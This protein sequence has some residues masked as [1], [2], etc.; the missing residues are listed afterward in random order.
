MI[1][2]L[3]RRMLASLTVAAMLALTPMA[4]AVSFSAVISFGDSLSDT[5]NISQATGGFPFS[6]PYSPGRFTSFFSDGT[7]GSTWVEYV[8]ANYGAS[9]LHSIACNPGPTCGTNYSWGGARTGPLNAGFPPSL[10]DQGSFYLNDVGG[11]AD[12]QALYTVWGGGNDI[13]AGDITGSVGNIVS[14]IT[15]LAGAGAQYFLVPNMPDIGLTPD[16]FDDTTGAL[17]TLRSGLTAD[18]NAG[19]AAELTALEA[20]LGVTIIQFDVFALFQDVLTDP[21]SYGISNTTERCYDSATSFLCADP[22]SYLF[23]DGVHPTAAVHAVL[24]GLAIDAVEAAL[25][26]IPAALPLM[27]TALAGLGVLRRR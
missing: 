1:D 21:S 12:S 11:A 15:T 23:F 7:A 19:L 25:I 4:S 10:L 24:G 16:S 17:T 14:L 6:P 18:F 5:G 3:R 13:L 22:D 8:S 2:S 27:L 9:S 20:N 26:P